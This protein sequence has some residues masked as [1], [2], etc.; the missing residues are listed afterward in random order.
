MLPD[1]NQM[2]ARDYPPN[3]GRQDSSPQNMA[4]QITNSG[5]SSICRANNSLS[6][7]CHWHS[8]DTLPILR[9]VK[10]LGTRQH[11]RKLMALEPYLTESL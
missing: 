11:K 3:L 4:R 6:H 5:P 10:L 9:F 1:T 7:P 2:L 8:R